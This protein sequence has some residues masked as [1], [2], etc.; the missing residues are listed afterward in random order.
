MND[1][2]RKELIDLLNGIKVACM[3]AIDKL[4]T[5]SDAKLNQDIYELD[6][7]VFATNRLNMADIYV[8]GDL[9][10]KTAVDLHMIDGI[11]KKSFC[12]IKD[13]LEKL[14]YSLKSL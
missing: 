10:N 4:H 11:G 6:L 12:E 14:G 7:S 3:K 5:Y 13:A 9:V 1:I 2:E 8:I